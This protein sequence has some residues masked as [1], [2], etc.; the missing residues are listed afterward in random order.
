[1]ELKTLTW[2]IGGGKL[3]QDGADPLRIASH[4]E[5]GIDAIA[6]L[7]ESEEPDVI[8]LQET[9]RKEGYD[10]AELIASS[11]GYEHYF[12]DSMS[13]SHI[14]TDCRLGHCV[15]SRYPIAQHRFGL[16]ENPNAQVTRE[17]GSTVT[18]HDK[19]FSSC[20][21]SIGDTQVEVTTLHLIPLRMFNIELESR[22]AQGM[23]EDVAAKLLPTRDKALIQGDFNI[24]RP[25]VQP[26]LRQ[27]FATAGLA[28]VAIDE[29]TTP[30]GR[31]HDHI[32]YR[33]LDLKSKRTVSGVRTDHYPVMATFEVQ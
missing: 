24:D 5:D 15:I 17:D 3:L 10:Q 22:T 8:A 32:L 4:A 30:G 12:H 13:E 28:E 20:V 1:M 9:Q 18:T 33:G 29:P 14:D 25:A 11:L 19:G 21:V 16:F 7:L 2:N 6:G 27:L 31:R 26:Y 23:L